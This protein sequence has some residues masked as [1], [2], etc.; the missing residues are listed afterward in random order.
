MAR[1]VRCDARMNL[2]ALLL[3]LLVAAPA[4]AAPGDSKN[5]G[6]KD[7][8]AVN[9]MTALGDKIYVASAVDL[10]EVDKR[11]NGKALKVTGAPGWGRTAQVTSLG[12]KLY[13]INEE[14]L[15]EIDPSGK[16]RNLGNEW[17]SV[18]GMT[19]LN[20]KLYIVADEG[21]YEVE[22]STGKYVKLSDDWYNVDGITALGGKLYIIMRDKLHEVDT[23]GQRKELGEAYNTPLALV[24]AGGN[25][26]AFAY[27]RRDNSGGGVINASALY[28][29]DESTGARKRI[30]MPKGWSDGTGVNAMAVLD[31]KLYLA[32]PGMSRTSFF[33]LD[34]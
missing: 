20:G 25:L 30:A 26:Y 11:G 22:P 12:G 15:Y 17:F 14:V 1:G 9:A 18:P 23:L 13:A 19:A 33:S 7:W 34:L 6:E 4:L 32:M 8:S 24:T 16:A 2:K 5:F 10:W 28:E 3:S 31:D 27:E 29:I 21:L